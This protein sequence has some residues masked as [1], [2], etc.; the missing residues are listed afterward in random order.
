MR[1]C[2]LTTLLPAW[3]LAS[4]LIVFSA[5]C[6][7]QTA[8]THLPMQQ[9]SDLL[10]GL[11][12]IV[13]ERSNQPNATVFLVTFAGANADE[14]GKAGA[15]SLTAR[16][17][18][19]STPQRKSAQIAEDFDNMGVHATSEAD[20]DASWFR[21]SG[22]A[23]T[24][25]AM[26]EQVSDLVLNSNFDEKEFSQLKERLKHEM[27][28]RR[29]DAGAL[30][31]IYFREKLYGMHPY[32]FPPE[33]VPRTIDTITREDCIR[34]HQRFYHPNNAVLL[35]VGGVRADEVVNKVRVLLGG[36]KNVAFPP[37]LPKPAKQPVG[38]LIRIGDR[39]SNDPA[40]IR[41]GRIGV[42]HTARDYYNLEM[43]NFLL[44]GEGYPSRFAERLQKKDQFT[45]GVSS[46]F[47][48]HLGGGEWM[49]SLTAPSA[50]AA[51]ALSD[52]LDE[53]KTIR[54]AKVTDQDLS[55]AIKTMTARLAAQLQTNNQIATALAKIEVYNL[56]F[57]AY[58][59]YAAHLK[60]VTAEQLQRT[61]REYL[62]PD[63][64]VVVVIGNSAEM[65]SA[66]E[67]ISTV[68]VFPGS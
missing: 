44:G 64:L 38:V 31:E 68:E 1:R 18:L 47:E 67:K 13:V 48:Y 28:A 17:L 20:Y 62:D 32:G 37:I 27:L 46:H 39:A 58:T 35:V 5:L 19:A 12:V 42:H 30:A 50:Q 21:M 51:T 65:K 26:L 16:M 60:R 63:S 10:N 49:I 11:K 23:K 34:F 9:R 24:V 25:S 2:V 33:G 52:L 56:A 43:L 66:L 36:W 22:P 41:V 59:A 8:F 15:A 40:Q 3:L 7:A 61:A 6:F 57:D 4:L 45:P 14:S 53:I 29:S 54:D 55:E